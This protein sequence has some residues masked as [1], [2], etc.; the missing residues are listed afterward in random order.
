[1]AKGMPKQEAVDTLKVNWNDVSMIE[2]KN[3]IQSLM[4]HRIK[5]AEIAKLV[6]R[7]I[8][9]VKDAWMGISE[10]SVFAQ[11]PATATAVG[12]AGLPADCGH[13]SQYQGLIAPTCAGGQGCQKCWAVFYLKNNI[14]DGVI[15]PKVQEVAPQKAIY[16]MSF[17]DILKKYRE[18]IGWQASPTP[19][20]GQGSNDNEYLNG[21]IISDIHAPFHDEASLMKTIAQTK[22]K[23]DVCIL[24]GDG[25]DFHNYSKY[26]KYGQ[27]FSI[28][29]EH[30]SFMAVLALL[31]ESYP[32]VV[33]IP[34]NHDERTR[35]K[36]AQMLPADMY[37]ALLDFHGGN[38]FD[39]AE[40]MTRQFENIIIPATPQSGFAEYRFLYQI[41]D[42]VVG[43]PELYS[44]I[45]NRSVGNFIDWTKKKAEPMG[46]VKS[47]IT[48]VVIGH[49][50][51]AGKTFNDFD[52][53]GIENGCLCMTPDYD[54]GA[55][56]AGAYRPLVRGYTLFRTSKK[57]GITAANDI[58]FI[59][60]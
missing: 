7:S 29:D 42:I 18:W 51:Q 3:L 57:T 35:K 39:F 26:M 36:Y 19:A 54:S 41:N 15:S 31:S 21:I 45:A 12:L 46:L 27:H 2:R 55:K 32:E 43:H 16:S 52:V 49:T 59:R 48:A 58:N 28:R 6:G 25:P 1:M 56:L 9:E 37:Q 60:V 5:F 8:Q 33:M 38:A 22:G 11:E 30:K 20:P 44:K 23:T 14:S 17:D 24:A 47:P 10:T 40:L 53:I 4:G 50:H 34:G 13:S